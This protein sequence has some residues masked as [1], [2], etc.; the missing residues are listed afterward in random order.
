MSFFIVDV[1]F[2]FSFQSLG[3][4]GSVPAAWLILTLLVL[5]IYLL[6]RCCDREHRPSRSISALKVTLAVIAVLCCGAIGLGLY[7]NDDLHNGLTHLLIQGKQVETIVSEVKNRTSTMV[8]INE[9]ITR[10]LTELRDIFEGPTANV[11]AAMNLQKRV[12][13][14]TATNERAAQATNDIRGIIAKVTLIPAI[15][16]GE[17][18]EYF[19]WPITMGVLSVLLVL[20]VILLV[21]V[22]RHSRC[23]LITFSVCGLLAVI[24]SW[25]LASIYLASTVALG[26]LCIAPDRYLASEAAPLIPPE[27]LLHYTHCETSRANPFTQRLREIKQALDTIRREQSILKPMASDLFRTKELGIKF[28]FLLTELNNAESVVSKLHTL[29]DCKALHSHYVEG[30]KG[31]CNIGL[32][33]LA[34]ML[35]SSVLSGLLFTIL[36]W[37]DS[38]TWIYIRKK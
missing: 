8:S 10:Q 21:G 15:S 7:G 17:K 38:H 13:N 2:C 9:R 14:I 19:R 30:A 27:V 31:L 24:S 22:A 18:I 32:M 33:G 11:S 20:C 12:D 29:L 16:L 4:L 23:A 35:L 37:V 36:V 28:S 6:T 25:L 3:I 26:D 1:N 5:L 34:L